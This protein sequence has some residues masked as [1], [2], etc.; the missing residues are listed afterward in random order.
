MSTWPPK[1]TPRRGDALSRSQGLIAALETGKCRIAGQFDG[2]EADMLSWE[3]G[4]HQPDSVAAAT[5]VF[6]TLAA[7]AG[8]R[9]TIAAPAGRLG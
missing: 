2:L 9:V 1:D 5:I 7:S 4:Q 6:E 8:A 3:A